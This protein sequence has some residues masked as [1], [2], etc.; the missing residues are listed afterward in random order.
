MLKKETINRAKFNKAWLPSVAGGGIGQS[1]RLDCVEPDFIGRY[2]QTA[3]ELAEN[4]ISPNHQP[5][6]HRTLF[7]Q[8]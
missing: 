7:R 8:V 6:S 3:A 5:F 2:F 1:R 4:G